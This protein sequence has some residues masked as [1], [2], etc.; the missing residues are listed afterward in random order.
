MKSISIMLAMA[1]VVFAP[2]QQPPKFIDPTGTYLLKGETKKNKIVGHSGEIRIKLLDTQ[3]VAMT[4]FIC[5]GFPNYETGSFIDTLSYTDNKVMYKP[6]ADSGC[7]IAF[8]FDDLSAETQQYFTNPRSACGFG[9]GVM[10]S[11]VF[12][13]RS[14][15]IPIIQDLSVR[16][17][18]Q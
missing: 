15:E 9:P 14:S 17:G 10:K 16:S 12:E 6:P 4:F 8:W 7:T 3:T 11:T 2:L 5:K 13:K 1:G 18:L